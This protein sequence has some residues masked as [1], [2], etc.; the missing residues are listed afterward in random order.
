[1]EKTVSCKQSI[2][3]FTLRVV[4]TDFLLKGHAVNERYYFALLSD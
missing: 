4:L 2:F 3:W 1:M